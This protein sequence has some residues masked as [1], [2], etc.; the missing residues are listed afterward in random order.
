MFDR[1]PSKMSPYIDFIKKNDIETIWQIHV[2]EIFTLA[3][4][5]NEN[6]I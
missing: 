2:D 3:S 1:I 6:Y 5:I 4:K